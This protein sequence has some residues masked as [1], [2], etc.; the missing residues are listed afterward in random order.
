[1]SRLFTAAVFA[2]LMAPPALA[3]GISF[4]LP[5]LTFPDGDVTISTANCDVTVG[6]PVCAPTKN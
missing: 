3:G 5:N 6:Q 1:M 2:V 4:D